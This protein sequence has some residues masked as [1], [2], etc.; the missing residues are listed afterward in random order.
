[1][2]SLLLGTNFTLDIMHVFNFEFPA[3]ETAVP[4]NRGMAW[5]ELV[6]LVIHP[7]GVQSTD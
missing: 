2:A 3:A 7:G 4:R 6:V 5:A 1:M